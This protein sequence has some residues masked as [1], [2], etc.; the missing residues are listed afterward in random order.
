MLDDIMNDNKPQKRRMSRIPGVNNRMS[1]NMADV[2]NQIRNTQAKTPKGGKVP[3]V[4]ENDDEDDIMGMI[5]QA[6][7]GA[8]ERA[9]KSE[10]SNEE[11]EEMMDECNDLMRD[12]QK[13]NFVYRDLKREVRDVEFKPDESIFYRSDGLT[14]INARSNCKSCRYEFKKES[15]M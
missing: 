10:S 2:Q 14:K 11:V 12:L 1:M 5:N 8:E 6:E 3:I 9:L 4:L 13:T 7:F 15:E